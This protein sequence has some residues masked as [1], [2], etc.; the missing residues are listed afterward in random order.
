[1][2]AKIETNYLQS[3]VQLTALSQVGFFQQLFAP[4]ALADIFDEGNKIVTFIFDKSRIDFNIPVTAILAPMTG[5]KGRRAVLHD[6]M[7]M[8]GY[9]LRGFQRLQVGDAHADQFSL[10]IAG[11]ADVGQIGLHN[12][13]I[14]VQS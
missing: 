14:S 8:L 5:F 3:I 1:M 7:N 2:Y 9:L 10:G 13:A 4:L 11:H 6:L 12:E